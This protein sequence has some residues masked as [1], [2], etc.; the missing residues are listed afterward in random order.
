MSVQPLAHSAKKNKPPQSYEDH[1]VGVVSESRENWKKM[2]C[3]VSEARHSLLESTLIR[4]AYL[5][6]LGKLDEKNQAVLLNSSESRLPIPHR[7]AGV[8]HLLDE[9]DRNAAIFV[10]AHHAPGLPNIMSEKIKAYPFRSNVENAKERT[11]KFLSEYLKK[12]TEVL[13]DSLNIPPAPLEKQNGFSPVEYRM[14]LS[15]LV[16]ADYSDTSGRK[17]TSEE[18]HWKERSKKLDEYIESLGKENS[19]PQDDALIER[20][21]SRSKLYEHCKTYLPETN[22]VYCESPVGTGKTTAIMAHLL[23][24]AQ[25]RNLRHIIVVLPYTN[26]ITE[27][28]KVYRKAL[29]LDGED[30]VAIVAEHHHQADYGDEENAYNSDLRSI[31]TTWTAP[32]IVTTAVQFFETLASNRPSKLRKIHQLPGSAVFVDESHAALPAKLMPPA[33]VWIQDLSKNWGCY[34][35]LA[36]GTPV[37]FWDTAEF[38]DIKAWKAESPEKVEALLSPELS[39]SLETFERNRIQNNFQ[40]E[41]PPHFENKEA[42]A[43]F[44]LS[45]TGP[46]L[47]VMNTVKSAAAL[48]LHLKN[49]NRD[50]LHLSTS[51]TPNDR[52]EILTEIY[53][54]LKNKSGDQND[55]TLVAT[56][57]V[58]CG[59]NFSFRNGFCELRSLQSSHQLSG[60]V[61]RNGEYRDAFLYCFTVNDDAFNKNPIFK[62]PI[63]VFNRLITQNFLADKTITEAVT[64]GFEMECK[65]SGGLPNEI[66]GDERIHNFQNVA[67]KFRIIDDNTV[68]V[69]ADKIL[70]ERMENGVDVSSI[71]IVRK[72]VNIRKCWITEL[73]LPSF[74]RYPELFKFS[75]AQ[76]D[77]KFLGYMKAIMDINP[78]FKCHFY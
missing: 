67:E 19:E 44:I 27:A 70:I 16:D 10:F 31:A 32:I 12:H 69:V 5:H 28:V 41:K 15:C 61:G 59:L 7:D 1:V 68:T 23:Q 22:I 38:K 37:K 40:N 49:T 73:K 26:I 53:R 64:L 18:P 45:K 17:F 35:C 34:F 36:S 9:N 52:E 50:V 63:S 46:R 42:L 65:E 75:E 13:S 39:Q 3:F 30:P 4:A 54:R 14:L 48:A 78:K 43:N 66:C 6:D 72:S 62:I 20:N 2:C 71:E 57:C 8:K 25:K 51:L 11:D 56:S 24:V 21:R 55:W 60:R 33:W 74:K 77:S 47:V 29:V 76:Y 58:E